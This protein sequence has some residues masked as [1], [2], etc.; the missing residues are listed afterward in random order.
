MEINSKTLEMLALAVIILAQNAFATE[1]IHE[2]N[3][4]NKGT[5]ECSLY[6]APSSIPHAGFGLFVSRNIAK[7]EYILPYSDA[8]S[9][10]VCD[11]YHEG[12]TD[13]DWN[14]VD[15]LWS[16]SGLAEHE[17]KEGSES[18]M[19]F[20]ALS[21]FHTYLANVHPVNEVYDD[22]VVDRQNN[23]ALGSFSLHAGHKFEAY[24]NLKAGDEIFADYGETWLDQ[25]KG[26]FADFVPREKDFEK[27]AI[28]F[29]KIHRSLISEKVKVTDSI[30][31]TLN[32]ISSEFEPR[33]GTILPDTVEKYNYILQNMGKEK[34]EAVLSRSNLLPRSL[35][36][37][38]EHGMC[39]DL[40]RPGK[41]TLKNAGLGA[42]SRGFIKAGQ[43][44]VPGPL[45]GI[46]DR[47]K[48]KMH[49]LYDKETE[50]FEK[51]TDDHK[52][53]G[54][55]LLLNYCFSHS[56]SPLALCP[57]TN[58]ILINHCSTTMNGE[59]HCSAAGPNAK[60][61][62][63]TSWD[64]DTEEWLNLSFEEVI[65]R[66][67]NQKRGLSLEVIAL[68]DIYPGEEVFIDYGSGWEAAYQRHLETWESPGDDDFVPV[69]KMTEERDFRTKEELVT[70]PY[71]RNVQL[72]CFFDNASKDH[73]DDEADSESGS[74][75]DYV[76][77]L[78]GANMKSERVE[79]EK[80]L[81]ECEIESKSVVDGKQT[82]TVSLWFE[83]NKIYRFTNYPE[84]SI[85]F[86]MKK[87]ESDQ[88]LP[89]AF[90][91]YIEIDDDMFPD[92]WKVGAYYFASLQESGPYVEDDDD[93]D[94]EYYHDEEEYDEEEDH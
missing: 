25:R 42:I 49:D 57:Q 44:I 58:M 93:E 48:L 74:E 45:L 56:L 31:R 54:S 29:K 8:P 68:R 28:L 24:D 7:G 39:L 94:Y 37:I 30:L 47:T 62:W 53:I 92:S 75:Y 14:H 32:A 60:I 5:F 34:L 50:E 91:H 85:L 43:I 16:G 83:K 36:Y 84:E 11:E 18:V 65:E 77:D 52:E 61:Q 73:F 55:Q 51:L 69:R 17:C 10:A 63:G 20:G 88:F 72:V 13:N 79:K 41:S 59:G 23:P 64:L 9:I 12:I 89:G 33:V 82:Y 70:N 81:Y 66:T 6:M 90:R 4:S 26:T 22:T 15:Y 67:Q 19:S 76:I 1:T 87:Y 78:D 27:A 3:E 71:P 35:D 38:K 86:R 2:Q 40:I 21:N 80:Y 46:K